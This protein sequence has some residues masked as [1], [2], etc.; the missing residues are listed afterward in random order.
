MQL[1]DLMEA[2]T[3]VAQAAV[4]AEREKDVLESPYSYLSGDVPPADDALGLG[5]GLG[6]AGSGGGSSSD[7]HGLLEGSGAGALAGLGLGLSGGGLGLGL[8][9]GS[10]ITVVDNL[11]GDISRIEGSSSSSSAGQGMGGGSKEGGMYP[12]YHPASGVSGGGGFHPARTRAFAPLL[13][14]VA[15]LPHPPLGSISDP[16]CSPASSDLFYRYQHQH[17]LSTSYLLYPKA[18]IL[19]LHV[20]SSTGLQLLGLT[21]TQILI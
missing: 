11:T 15:S 12:H 3:V 21:L 8:S 18:L 1:F 7:Y 6:C 2:M 20:T 4:V 13:L 17:T 14:P 10:P 5:P 9:G 19:T 16:T